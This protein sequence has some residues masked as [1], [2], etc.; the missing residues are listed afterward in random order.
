[1]DSNASKTKCRTNSSKSAP[2]SM[3][4]SEIWITK[5]TTLFPSLIALAVS[6]NKDDEVESSLR[7]LSCITERGLARELITID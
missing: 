5:K 2:N 4:S 7:L 3:R 6:W 1:M